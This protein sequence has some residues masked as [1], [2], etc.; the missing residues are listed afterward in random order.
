M[1]A[2]SSEG[3]L[4]NFSPKGKTSLT[5]CLI[6]R[7]ITNNMIKCCQTA[8][9]KCFQKIFNSCLANG[10]YP[11]SWAEGYV[12]PLHKAKDIYDPSNYRGITI[13]N[14]IG[15]LFNRILNTRLD[16]FLIK[17]KIIDDC[18]IGFTRKARTS[19]HVF[20]LKTLIDKYCT[21]STGRLYACFVDFQKAFDTVI[22][23]GIKLKL[24]EIG[25]GNLFYNVIKNMYA[26]SKY[27]IKINNEVTDHFPTLLGVKQGDNLSPNLFKIF[28]NNLAEYLKNSVDP[29][30]LKNRPLHCLMYADDVILL[31]TT[32]EGLQSKINILHKYCNDWCLNVNTDKSKILIFN[33][34]GRIIKHDFVLNKIKLECVGKYKYLGIHFCA[35]G[36]FSFTQDE[37]YK[38]ALKAYFKLSKD[39]L[40]L[41]PSVKTS[42]HVFDH[43]IKPIL[44]Y[45]SEIWGMFNP[46]S[47]KYRNGI[48][49]FD[50][51]YSKCPAEKLH[52][53]FCK[54]I[55]GVH[56]KT[57]NIAVLSE[58]GRFPLYFNIIKS[59]LR[60]YDRLQKSQSIFPLLFDS[61]EESK[62][63]H[64]M[65]KV[66]WYTSVHSLIDKIK[67]SLSLQQRTEINSQHFKTYFVK[68]WEQ[69]L[70][71]Y[72]DSKLCTYILHKKNFGLENY[73]LIIKDFELRRSLTRLR[74]SSHTLKIEKGRHLGIP[75]H[76]RLCL[77][78]SDG[79]VEDETHFLLTC[80]GLTNE[81]QKLLIAINNVC[82]NF[83][84]LDPKN[85]L[86]WLMSN[87]NREVLYELC[88]FIT[89]NEKLDQTSIR[90]S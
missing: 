73:L 38:K 12:K 54:F 21:N 13:T 8:L 61:F 86:I 83:K 3:V 46:W 5:T 72:S 55:L 2:D 11:Q 37:L 79:E 40:S 50:Q 29:V 23:T 14:A 41:Y 85:Q 45:G 43:T 20:V 18:Q 52:L 64:N 26:L 16:K 31:S 66:S 34:A 24:L 7:N 58:L 69:I 68:E 78:C 35:S 48:V 28:I 51:I 30:L 81:R 88:M 84:S 76:N 63:L 82:K 74:L 10:V 33:K 32:P 90:A 42:T 87:E 19:D 60:Y 27:C 47:S 71:K 59:M 67:S 80:K 49:S 39:F 22:H 6:W 1:D 44:T 77:R 62:T 56:S 4:Q 89:Q 25:V 53:K 36:S 57:T 70:Q 65:K 9:L 17:Y 75:R 15:K